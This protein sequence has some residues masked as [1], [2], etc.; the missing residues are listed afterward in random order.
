MLFLLAPA[1]CSTAFG[2]EPKQVMV[3]HSFGREAKPWSDFARS[4]HSELERQSPWPLDIIDYSLVS[5]R[6]SDEDLEVPFVEY[7]RALYSKHPLDLIVSVGAPA[8]AFVQRHRRQLFAATPMVLSVVEQRRV[9]YST[10]TEND[11]VVPVRIDYLAAIGN[12]LQVLPDTKNVSV[13]VGASPIEQFWRE[14]IRKDV[15]PFTDRVAFTFWDDLPFE[16]I[17]KH[18]AALPPHSAIFWELMVVDAAG[19]VHDGD[20]AFMNLHAAANAPI[21][22]YYEPN[23][24]QGAVGGPYNGVLELEPGD[25]SGRC[26]HPW[27]REGGRHP[28][29]ASRIFCGEIRLAGNAALGYRRRAFAAGK[30][31]LFSRSERMGPI[32]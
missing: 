9:E 3:L 17:L 15:M 32:Q 13:V 25:S 8:A 21:F 5:A 11:A 14:Q 20:T 30:H 18:A 2:A 1:V 19:V 6:S 29:T 10:L 12:I 28:D 24:G 26:S 16:D 4:I 22:G 31:H 7:L 27:W 23:I